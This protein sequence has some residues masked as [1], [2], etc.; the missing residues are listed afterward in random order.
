[1]SAPQPR[2]SIVT[3]NRGHGRYLRQCIDSVL[4]QGHPDVEHL[5]FDAGS[6]DGSVEVLRS[7]GDAISWVSA[8][9]AGQAAAIN[10]GFRKATGDVVAWLNSD[11]YYLPGA[12]DAAL[13]TLA[14][15]PGAAAVHGN[16]WMVDEG[17]ARVRRYPTFSLRRRDLAPKCY[18]CQPTVF[19]R[20][21][22]LDEVG[23]LN[24]DLEL[25]F[26][27]EWWLRILRRHRMA[28][29]ERPL[30]ATRQH[31]R[32]KT[33]AR[34]SRGL[35]EAGW[36]TRHHFGQPHWR[37][38]AKWAAHRWA[39]RG[40]PRWPSPARVVAGLRSGAAYRRRFAASS[41][42]SPFGRRMLASL[43]RHDAPHPI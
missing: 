13:D 9:D 27:Y 16:A 29:C 28:F 5:V 22:L 6:Q 15:D 38:A 40:D 30:A 2:I 4:A 35:I 11:D 24:D 18:V 1:V 20:R 3:P 7:Y 23:L 32:T 10:E 19:L 41:E 17:G 33:R 21:E 8:P 42:P 12:F 25:C 37:W 26:D 43:A 34:R 36:V 39:V 31:A 14:R